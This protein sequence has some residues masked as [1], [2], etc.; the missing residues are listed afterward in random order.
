[1]LAAVAGNPAFNAGIVDVYDI[2]A[3]LPPP[4]AQVL[5]RRSASS[6]TRAAWRPTAAPSTRPRPAPPT[7]RRGR[8][9]EPVAAGADL[10]IGNYDSHGLSISRRRQPRLRRRRSASG[11]IILDTS[12]VQARVAESR[13]C[14][15]IS[16]LDLG[17]DEHPAER[18][19][20]H[21][22]R[23]PLRR[24]DRRVRQRSSEGR[25][26]RASSTS[27]TRRSRR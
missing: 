10:A 16:R 7:H 20:D 13:R 6:A 15:E 21:D 11:L 23:P 9:L 5:A 14:A 1:M 8:H 3:G 25:R 19:P 2:S 12:E 18:D 24:R 4:G 27:P 22:Q 26:R 17:H